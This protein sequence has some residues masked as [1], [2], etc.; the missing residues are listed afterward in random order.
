MLSALPSWA[1]NGMNMIGYGA[2]SSGM[3]GADLAVVE[4]ASAM[5]INPAGICSCSGPQLTLGASLLMPELH[6]HDVTNSLDAKDS[7]SPLP[8]ITYVTPLEGTN[9]TIGIGA[10]AQGGMGVEYKNVVTP[11]M[12]R[13]ELYS[14]VGYLK[15]TPT[16]AWQSPD[17]R[18]KLG[19][20]VHLGRVET[21]I[22]YFPNTTMPGMFDGFK[23]K[24][25]EATGFGVRLGFQYELDNLVIGGSWLSKTDLDFDGGSLS[26]ASEPGTQINAEM[27]GF[28]WPQRVG[29]GFVYNIN[30][31]FRIAADIDWIEW[32]QALETVTLTG[33]PEPILFEMDWDDQ[34]VYA[35]G[36]EWGF[37][38]RWVARAGYNYG[39]SPVPDRTLSALFPAI[40][41][42]HATLG[43][44]YHTY[45]WKVDLA[46]EHGFK[47]EQ[48]N[49][50]T[51]ATESHEQKT[52]HFM[53][54]WLY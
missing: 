21:E 47:N 14:H 9:L 30:Y 42:E 44:G 24:D 36:A 27:K 33:G 6:H 12:T 46:Y 45:S 11:F 50:N 51:G 7:Y 31:A 41:E 3:G 34:W 4:N 25:L 13:D 8:L 53:L 19:A 23:V 22:K 49:P 37:T 20:S 48:T 38:E 18:L 39:E 10:F 54:T 2:V 5:N 16:L 1:T 17:S 15:I 40:V 26:L 35:I 28:N 32:S 52:V 29:L 43:V